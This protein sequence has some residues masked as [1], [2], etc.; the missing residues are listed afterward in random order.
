MK[1]H[2]KLDELLKNSSKVKILRFLFSEKDEHT[3]RAIARAINMSVSSTYENLQ[4]LK[5]EGLIS[6]RKKGNS[7]LYSIRLEN[8]IVRKLLNPLFKQEQSIFT[9]IISLIK[10]S[11]SKNT[12]KISSIAF[13]G[14]VVRKEE[15]VKSDIDLLVVAK[16]RQAKT[17]ITKA[18]D[19]LNQDIAKKYGAAISPYLVTKEEL[20][21]KYISKKAIVKS[22]LENNQLILGEP[23]ERIIA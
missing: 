2:N 18:L 8:Q 6:L 19:S 21:N 20:K 7:I 16:N 15:T 11:L 4:N 13:F 1:I 9:D 10:K 12:L 3:G 14:S 22:I 17:E 5:E 23:I